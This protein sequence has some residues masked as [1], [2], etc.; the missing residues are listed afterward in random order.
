MIGVPERKTMSWTS[1][2]DELFLKALE[3]YE[4]SSANLKEIK[5][6]IGLSNL[7]VKQVEVL[8]VQLQCCD[9][10]STSHKHT[11]IFPS[12]SSCEQKRHF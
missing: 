9:S 4:I 1:K 3:T 2:Q 8:P 10:S 5:K 11:L 12:I 7:T 6:I